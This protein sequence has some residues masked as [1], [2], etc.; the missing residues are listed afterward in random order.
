MPKPGTARSIGTAVLPARSRAA[1][2]IDQRCG[3][4]VKHVGSCRRLLTDLLTFWRAI[5]SA[6]ILTLRHGSERRFKLCC[7]T[8]LVRRLR[9]TASRRSRSGSPTA[10]SRSLGQG[11][12]EHETWETGYPDWE[13]TSFRKATDDKKFALAIR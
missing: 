11:G 7:F 4:E 6:A 1:R 8:K 12:T 9:T 5:A 10:R 13:N 3:A 2:A